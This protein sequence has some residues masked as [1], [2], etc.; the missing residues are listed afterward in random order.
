[1]GD[2]NAQA[3]ARRVYDRVNDVA[4]VAIRLTHQAADAVAHADNRE[5]PQM[6]QTW[7]GMG[8]VV[9]RL[10]EAIEVAI[11]QVEEADAEVRK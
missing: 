1:M 11:E 6:L 4:S 7:D 3:M 10:Q 8:E 5:I 2:E 9:E